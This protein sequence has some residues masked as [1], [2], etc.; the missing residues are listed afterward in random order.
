MFSGA[1]HTHPQNNLEVYLSIVWLVMGAMFVTTITSTLAAVLIDARERK[2]DVNRK[3][4]LLTLYMQQQQTPVLLALAVQ[5]N[6]Q[7]KLVMPKTLTEHDLPFFENIA[8]ALRA[9]LRVQR[10]SDSFLTL[11]LFRMLTTMD[12]NILQQLVF[13]ASTVLILKEG[14][15]VFHA[16]QEMGHA[17]LLQDGTTR[18]SPSTVLHTITSH[19]STGSVAVDQGMSQPT[20]GMDNTKSTR[21]GWVC[22]PVW[23]CELALLITWTTTGTLAAA[24]D[25]CEFLVVSTDHFIRIVG[26]YPNIAAVVA[27]Y[28]VQ[29]CEYLRNE[30]ESA[31]C[32]DIDPWVD[33]DVI[34]SCMDLSIRSG[35]VSKPV[36]ELL[37]RQNRLRGRLQ[38]KDF[39]AL[40]EEV[41]CGKSHLGLGH[42]GAPSHSHPPNSIIRVVQLV[43]LFLTNTDGNLCVQL[44]T[45]QGGDVKGKFC[46]PGT[47]MRG[48]ESPNDALMRLY[49]THLSSLIEAIRILDVETKVEY[50]QSTRFHFLHTKYIKHIHRAELIGHLEH[51]T[52]NVPTM[53]IHSERSR[54]SMQLRKDFAKHKQ[55]S[56]KSELSGAM[57]PAGSGSA[58][59]KRFRT[60]MPTQIFNDWSEFMRGV[61]SNDAAT[62][63]QP[64]STEE[65]NFAFAVQEPAAGH[66]SQ[67]E[68]EAPQE[69]KS[70]TSEPAVDETSVLRIY[71]WM[72]EA[73]FDMLLARRGEVE[74]D[75]S[76]MG[77]QLTQTSWSALLGWKL[78]IPKEPVHH[79][80]LEAI[81]EPQGTI[82]SVP[83]GAEA[84]LPA[85]GRADESILML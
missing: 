30:A 14:E 31:Q 9:A 43:V 65:P 84:Q 16:R 21:E 8:P 7:K 35:L 55:S 22:G 80:S 23:V 75:V 24:T 82:A 83:S 44:A 85:A 47:K 34:L 58:S 66:A 6:F 11:P 41:C 52:S 19:L 36:L 46:L 45:C 37:R 51:D 29:L 3:M 79:G 54:S 73:D 1:S 71:K 74:F 10:Y 77:A 76:R 40:E 42:E 57:V 72:D 68:P 39:L 17:T 48:N 63:H 5:A 53:R 26:S 20:M 12:E 50:S 81:I 28:A 15:E 60:K 32:S 64:F 78:R 33:H 61:P 38:R 49:R 70:A 4:K 62:I 59:F 67:T 56:M 25:N 18:Y 13:E 27:S 69:D 2:Q